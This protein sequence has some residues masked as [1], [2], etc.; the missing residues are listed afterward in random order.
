MA[1]SVPA[2]IAVG[3]MVFFTG[4]DLSMRLDLFEFLR[5]LPGEFQGESRV[6]ENRTHGLV[7]EVKGR[8]LGRT[9][10]TLVERVPRRLGGI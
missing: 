1:A 5:M 6:W 7:R 9:T 3:Q 8:R 2:D 10:F 4:K